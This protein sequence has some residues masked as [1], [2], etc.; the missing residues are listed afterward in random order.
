MNEGIKRDWLSKI[1]MCHG[2]Y[3]KALKKRDVVILIIIYKER[4]T[5]EA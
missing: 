2:C 3:K 4:N 5:I 1:I